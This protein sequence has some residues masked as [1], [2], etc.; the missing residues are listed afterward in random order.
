M[1]KMVSFIFAA[2]LIMGVSSAC[3]QK[4]TV[5]DQSSKGSTASYQKNESYEEALKECFNASFS[6]NGGQI[7]YAYMYPDEYINDMKDK[8]DYND[9]VNSF[10]QKQSERPDLTDGVFEFGSI[11]ESKPIN[12]KQR[13]AV[14][15]YFADKCADRE[16]GITE[17]DINIGDGYEVSYTYLKNGKEEGKDLVLAVEINDQGWK[18]I[19]S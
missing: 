6:T 13:D 15:A 1:N 8:G 4:Q 19:P 18:V 11:T 5:S 7:F 2:S 12:D 14:K 3:G 16:I 9:I 17:D 10:N